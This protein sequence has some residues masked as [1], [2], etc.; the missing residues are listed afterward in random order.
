M[1][2]KEIREL[3]NLGHHLGSHGYDHYWWTKLS[4]AKLQNELELSLNFLKKFDVDISSW[5]A[6]YPYGYHDNKVMEILKNKG[7]KVAFTVEPKVGSIEEDL[8]KFPRLDTN[9]LPKKQRRKYEKS[10]FWL[11]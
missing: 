5:S 3:K 1:S 2:E 10:D 6:C 4:D 9:D 11:W 8:L 7:C